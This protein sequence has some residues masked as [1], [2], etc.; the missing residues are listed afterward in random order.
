MTDTRIEAMLEDLHRVAP[1]AVSEQPEFKTFT[2][3]RELVAYLEKWKIP[4]SMRWG[5][6][7]AR[8]CAE[9]FHQLVTHDETRLFEAMFNG[10]KRIFRYIRVLLLRVVHD[11]PLGRIEYDT[12]HFVPDGDQLIDMGDATV[13]P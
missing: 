2:L 4:L 3:L 10:R 13:T 6:G 12:D 5:K 8:T 9:L 7:K 11:V 1:V